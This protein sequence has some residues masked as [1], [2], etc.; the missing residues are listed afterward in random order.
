[1]HKQTNEAREGTHHSFIP[2]RILTTEER[3][4]L[5]A[6]DLEGVC[7]HS[8]DHVLINIE[9]SLARCGPPGKSMVSQPR[10]P[11]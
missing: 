10:V 5:V 3:C 9:I 7:D 11:F 4:H 6:V 2:C 1:M 8:F